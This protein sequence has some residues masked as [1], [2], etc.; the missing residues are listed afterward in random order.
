MFQSRFAADAALFGRGADMCAAAIASGSSRRPPR[1]L[2]RFDRSHAC[3][4]W[5]LR[6]DGAA[7]LA[8]LGASPWQ[9]RGRAEAGTQDVSAGATMKPGWGEEARTP[10]AIP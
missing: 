9:G 6:V 10:T 1:T 4:A 2:L 3:G 5:H 8:W 7:L